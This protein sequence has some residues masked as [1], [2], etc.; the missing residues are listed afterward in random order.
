MWRC[1]KRPATRCR[2][3]ITLRALEARGHTWNFAWRCS[4]VTRER[5]LGR[6]LE[7]LLGSPLP[8]VGGGPSLQVVGGDSAAVGPLKVGVY[9]IEANPFQPRRDFDEAEIDV[10]ADSLQ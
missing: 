1:R 2:C 8:S 7:A 10:L 4:N 9:D 6:G 5:R 3:L